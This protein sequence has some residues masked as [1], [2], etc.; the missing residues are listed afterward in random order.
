MSQAVVEL[1]KT[2]PGVSTLT[3]CGSTEKSYENKSW[4][5]GAF[6]EALL[7]AFNGTTCSDATGQFQAD[8]DQDGILRLGE[9]YDF[10][11]RR[12]PEL[13]KA[14]VPNAPTSQTP[15]MPESEL[16]KQ[17]PLYILKSNTV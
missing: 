8:K 14:E 6:T 15:F 10:L 4:E 7:N 1:A 12:V 2:Q 3:S 13:V 9:L 16:D 5:N 11:R 17:L